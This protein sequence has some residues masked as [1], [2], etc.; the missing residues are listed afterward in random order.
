LG[1]DA[2]VA[3]P[4]ALCVPVLKIEKLTRK[5]QHP[6]YNTSAQYYNHYLVESLK[7]QPRAAFS[8]HYFREITYFWGAILCDI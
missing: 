3:M 7:T 2:D 5:N 8:F 6:K 4:T 1:K